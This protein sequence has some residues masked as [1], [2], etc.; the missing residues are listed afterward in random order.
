MAGPDAVVVGSGPNGL[1]A[2]IELARAGLSVEV[3]EGAA[4][5][6]GGCRTAELTLPG[7]HHDVC[8]AIPALAALSPFF[9]SLDLGSLGVRLRTP[10]V[11]FA[12]PLDGG[13]AAGVQRS[14]E[15]TAKGLGADAPAYRRLVGPLVVRAPAIAGAAMAPLLRRVPEHPA[16][17]AGFGLSG[18]RSAAGLARR[19]TTPQARGLLGGASAHSMLSLTAPLSGA[20]GLVLTVSAHAGGWPVVEGGTGRLVEGLLRQLERLGA[21]V[22]TGCWISE[23]RQLPSGALALLDTSPATLL[24]LA[25][26]ELPAGYRRA[27]ARFRHGPGICKVDWALSGP[28]P[29]SADACRR[30][31]T[32]H[33]GG[34]FE[35]VAASEAEV[36]AGRHPPSPY[37]LVVQPTVIDPT[38]APA[39]RH[40]LWAYC[41]VPAGSTVDMTERIE[42]QVERFAP[43]FRDLV[44]ARATATAA[45]VA[46]ANPNYVG[47]DVN[48]GAPTLSQ[49]IFRPVRRWNPYRTPLPGLYLCSASTP[50][51]GG[52]HG[53]C[54]VWAARTAL[55]DLRRGRRPRA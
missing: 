37:C 9:A 48:G 27:L 30:A 46:R 51:G 2:A 22:R 25:G 8:S 5:P 15:A 53:M 21:S 50:P 26:S 24:R 38:R 33:L 31:G 42:A 34:S 13:R 3:L 39:G 17:V 40:T 10:E 49:T 11:A 12:H 6:G 52:V 7:F 54:G 4:T 45:E 47:G 16:A 36:A 32:V 43:G 55:A 44:L 35:E 20:Y 28:V 19:F 1:A 18:L 41:H 23:R 29:W 14:V